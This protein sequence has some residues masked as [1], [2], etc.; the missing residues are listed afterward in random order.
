[1]IS[2]GDE[3]APVGAA[4]V[5]SDCA[6]AAVVLSEAAGALEAGV[7]SEGDGVGAGVGAGVGVAAVVDF[8]VVEVCASTAFPADMREPRKFPLEKRRTIAKTIIKPFLISG[9]KLSFEGELLSFAITFS[10]L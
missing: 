10:F 3:G 4:G 7:L 1:M 9:S 2:A 5:A 8:A 6:G